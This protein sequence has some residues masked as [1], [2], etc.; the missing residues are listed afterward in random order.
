V[1]LHVPRLMERL[2]KSQDW[3]KLD[4]KP[5]SKDWRWHFA[6]A[7]WRFVAYQD[8][9]S[10]KDI[11]S[12]AAR[13]DWRAAST[14]LL[15]AA[16]LS[17]GD[18]LEGTSLVAEEL[19]RDKAAPLDHA[20]LHLHAAHLAAE[21]GHRDSAR[22]H[23]S[24]AVSVLSG[25][26]DDPTASL[27]SGIAYRTLFNL[28]S[29][30]E[31]SESISGALRAG[32][33]AGSWWRDQQLRWAL[34]A[35]AMSQFREWAQDDSSRWDAEPPMQQLLPSML[36]ALFSADRVGLAAAEARL[37]RFGAQCAKTDDEFRS[38]FAR[39]LNSGYNELRGHMSPLDTPTLPA[40]SRTRGS[41]WQKSTICPK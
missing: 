1:L 6:F 38:G 18:P 21:A 9:I 8:K 34:D 15:A 27:L 4:E 39:M 17:I 31:S 41:D 3:P 13:E 36:M 30:K 22:L 16:E 40:S 19:A 11:Q 24:Q 37:G 5:P 14:V 2:E 7:L 28:A 35:A 23:A 26:G 25:I 12:T 33:N 29:W 20:W 32:D 10:L